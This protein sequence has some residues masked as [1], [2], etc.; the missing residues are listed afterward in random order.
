MNYDFS[1]LSDIDF[2]QMVNKLL[3]GN[4]RYVSVSPTPF[5][6]MSAAEFSFISRNLRSTSL[7]LASEASWSS[8]A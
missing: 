3:N 1:V 2:E 5:A 4:S 7:T 6:Y 8:W